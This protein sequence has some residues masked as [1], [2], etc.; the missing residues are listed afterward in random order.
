MGHAELAD[1]PIYQ[2]A[3]RRGKKVIR[4]IHNS[5]KGGYS[6]KS[7]TA[8]GLIEGGNMEEYEEPDME[9]DIERQEGKREVEQ[10]VHG[11]RNGKIV[12]GPARERRT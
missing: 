5:P 2:E 11:L 8:R 3:R 12:E 9:M 4:D 7:R 6:C 1:S 10:F